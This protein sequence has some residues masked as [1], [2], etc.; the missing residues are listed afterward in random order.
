MKQKLR[1]ITSRPFVV[2]LCAWFTLSWSWAFMTDSLDLAGSKSVAMV[3]ATW[4]VIFN[5]AI[6]TFIVIKTNKLLRTKF[7]NY[8]SW[9]VIALGLPLFALMDFVIS[10]LTAIIWL[11]PQGS[12]DNISPLTSPTVVLINSPFGF[13]SRLVGFYGLSAFFWLTIFLLIDKNRRKYSLFV[14]GILSIF[15]LVGWIGYKTPQGNEIKATIVSENLDNRVG[16]MQNR[17]SKL[18]VFPE[19]G[20]D[21]INNENLETRLAKNKDDSK[22]YFLGSQEVRDGRPAGHLNVLVF[23]S[24]ETGIISSQ[25]KHRLIPGG[26][27]LAYIGRIALRA[28]NQKSTLDYFSY[29]K[30]VNKGDHPLQ[31]LRVDDSTILGSAVCSSIIAP[32]DYRIF[33]KQGATLFTNSASLTIFKGSKVFAWQ[34]KSM[35]RFMAISNSRYFLQSANAATAYVLDNNGKQLAEVRGIEAKDVVAKNNTIKTPYTIIGEALVAT[36][37]LIVIYWLIKIL[38]KRNSK[39]KKKTKKQSVKKVKS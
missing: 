18:V 39:T 9:L 29:A 7:V 24:S 20:L 27:D 5:V 8:N 1:K 30:M 2:F 35:A 22:T 16:V 33:A 6:A 12:I 13:A 17:D 37:L 28:T 10:W 15:S 26:E 36:G 31:P 38:K 3:I 14:V 11:G 23:G 32:K 34:Q 19:Y 21:E 25:Q 4:V